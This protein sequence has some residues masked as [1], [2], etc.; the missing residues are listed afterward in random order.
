M[1]DDIKE[2]LDQLNR[3]YKEGNELYYAT[4]ARLNLA[5]STLMILYGLSHTKKACTQK[6]LCDRWYLK[7]QTL[8]SA[9]NNLIAEGC[10][11]L[12]PSKESAREKLI[13]LTG[14]GQELCARTAMPFLQAEQRAF[15]ML[16]SKE[17]KTLLELTQ[18][19]I[20]Y[21]KEQAK[22][23]VDKFNKD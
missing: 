1:I 16:S 21:I 4:A 10:V 20:N 8:N 22:M 9:L 11:V 18:K 6:Q 23:L 12:E 13:I 17:R 7:K 15:A 19:H 5:P 14:K 3:L 2:Q